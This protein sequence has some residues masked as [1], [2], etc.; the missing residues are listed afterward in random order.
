MRKTLALFAV[1]VIWWNSAV[2]QETEK[3]APITEKTSVAKMREMLAEEIEK[4][5]V[6]I[7]KIGDLNGVP[8]HQQESEKQKILQELEEHRAELKVLT[9]SFEQLGAAK[10]D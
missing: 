3:T 2:A 1:L 9:A 8:Q 10:K 5:I 6:I 4:M 7:Q